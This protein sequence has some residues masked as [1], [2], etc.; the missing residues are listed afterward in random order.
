MRKND[1]IVLYLMLFLL[2]LSSCNSNV[3]HSETK[4]IPDSKWNKNNI[5][6]YNFKIEDTLQPYN[7]YLNIRNT[8]SYQFRN[9]FLFIETTSPQGNTVR[10]TFECMLANEKGKW[11][12]K[13]WGDIYENKIPYKQ[14]IRFP[15]KGTYGIEIQQA[16]RRSNLKHITDIGVIIEEHRYSRK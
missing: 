5:L 6:S 4:D 13:G 12:G 9:L 3:I 2:S 16:M 7:V 1:R 10:D 14:Y 11:Y 8:S 15:R